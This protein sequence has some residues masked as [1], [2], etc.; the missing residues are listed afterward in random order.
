MV[1]YQMILDQILLEAFRTNGFRP[2]GFRPNGLRPGP[3]GPAS[4]GLPQQAT[5]NIPPSAI[6]HRKS[7]KVQFYQ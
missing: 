1:L 2:N 3:H 6:K 5:K 7:W 4:L